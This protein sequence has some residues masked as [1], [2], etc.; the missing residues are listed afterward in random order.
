MNKAVHITNAILNLVMAWMSI[1]VGRAAFISLFSEMGYYRFFFV[2]ICVFASYKSC[3]GFCKNI[4]SI[5]ERQEDR[6]VSK[7][8]T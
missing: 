2:A 8:E 1:T 6:D 5:A 4:Y 7:C 3:L